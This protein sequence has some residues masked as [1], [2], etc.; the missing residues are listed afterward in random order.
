LWLSGLPEQAMETARRA[1]TTALKSG[2]PLDTCFALIFTTPVYLWCGEWDAAQD[3]LEQLVNHTHWP[4]LKPFHSSATALQ[5]A[6]LIGRNDA[7]QGT[8]MV[9]TAL[10]SMRNERQKVDG[11]FVACWVAEGLMSAGRPEQALAV[12]RDARRDAVLRSEAV[13][14][15]E[16]LRLQ[17][18][19]LLATSE[20]HE[21]QAERLLVRAC[22]IAHRQ[23]AL[24]WEL[25]AGLDLARL[26]A[27]R[28]NCVEA[29]QLLATTYDRFTEG[30]ATHD[31]RAATQLLGELEPLTS[32]AAV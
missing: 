21:A 19:A 13:L 12:V 30:F 5:G 14:L 24:A 17:G 32:R 25:R 31:L 1:V 26:R 29:R 8:P 20:T 2:K 9:Q 3:V 22:S 7:S 15:P 10:Q 18:Q 4:V 28:G 27:R 23:S 16:L 6:L 11:T